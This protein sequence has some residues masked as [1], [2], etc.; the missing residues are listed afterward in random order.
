[1]MTWRTI[2]RRTRRGGL[3]L[4]WFVGMIALF[5][6]ATVWANPQSQDLKGEVLDSQ[7]K[8]IAGAR[9]T[10]AG[11]SLPERGLSVVTGEQGEF[12]FRGLVE[13][14]YDLTCAAVEH[15]PVVQQGLAITETG[16]PFVQV[17]LPPT[18]VVRE[19]VEVHA[20]GGK[21]STQNSAR[22]VAL[23]AQQLQ[24]LPLT[25]QKFL[26][27]LPLIPGVV[28]TPDGKINIKGTVENQGM[29]LVDN[30]ETVDPVTGSFS[31]DVP[32]DAV[33]SLEVLKTTLSKVGL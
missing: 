26:A 4:V 19:K 23:S 28:R 30:A 3:A 22:V 25:E 21:V 6:L 20:E 1:M 27:A 13:G 15:E 5:P 9:C 14:S 17:V 2:S 16:A 33:A 24:T 10:L 7:N 18:V 29:L 32:I 8:P 12:S 31:I 11:R